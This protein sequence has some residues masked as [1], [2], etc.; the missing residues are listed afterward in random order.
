MAFIISCSLSLLLI[1][2]IYAILS[3][4]ICWHA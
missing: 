2:Y 3:D 1:A 4:T